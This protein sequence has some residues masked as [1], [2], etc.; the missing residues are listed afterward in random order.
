MS[1][2]VAAA[3]QQQAMRRP[4]MQPV[5][6]PPV[7][8]PVPVSM[9]HVTPVMGVLP[10]MPQFN[11]MRP[12]QPGQYPAERADPHTHAYTQPSALYGDYR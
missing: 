5:M 7:R 12:L 6:L 8:V 2:A 10:V 1:A 3:R 4:L 9:P 11:L